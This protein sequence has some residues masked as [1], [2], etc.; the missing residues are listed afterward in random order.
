[1]VDVNLLFSEC[2]MSLLFLFALRGFFIA[3]FLFLIDQII[4]KLD[5]KLINTLGYIIAG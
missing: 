3:L 4:S 2:A 5:I 1:M